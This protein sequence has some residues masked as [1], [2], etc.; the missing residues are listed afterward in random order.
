MKLLRVR[1][2]VWRLMT[3]LVVVLTLFFPAVTDGR[4]EAVGPPSPPHGDPPREAKGP[5]AIAP[6]SS[7][8][9]RGSIDAVTFSPDGKTLASGNGE[10]VV[11]FYDPANGRERAPAWDAKT[12]EGINVLAYS[13]DGKTLAVGIFTEGVR[14]LDVATRAPRFT[15]RVPPPAR[16]LGPPG[17]QTLTALAYSPDG[18]TLAGATAN[19]QVAVWDVTTGRLLTLMVGPVI[20]PKRTIPGVHNPGRPAWLSGLVYAPDGKS[21]A[22]MGHENVVR[23]WDPAAGQERFTVLASYPAY[24][25]DGKALAVGSHGDRSGP[26]AAAMLDPATGRP[27]SV[28][29]GSRSGPVAFVAG[30][31][32]LVSFQHDD[33]TV[34]LW[35]VTTGRPRDALRLEGNGGLKQFVVSSDG[36]SVVLAGFGAAGYF[37]WIE[38]IETDGA[39]L[40]RRKPGR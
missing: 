19:G 3:T 17:L 15:L 28:F 37:G 9:G 21:L 16:P 36:Q 5:P 32:A 38:L 40:Q 2:T 25:P 23:V 22:T 14:L 12:I 29:E 1:F 10:G 11:R 18:A 8:R 33:W 13:P 31:K 26:G 24:S 30:G 34:R 7:R 35:D 6:P 20:P 27:R 4:A 39:S